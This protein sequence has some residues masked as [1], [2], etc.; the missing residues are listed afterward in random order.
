MRHVWRG[1]ADANDPARLQALRD[2]VAPARDPGS[3]AVKT[4]LRAHAEVAIERGVFGVPTIDVEGRLFWGLDSLP[5]VRS[6][7]HGDAWFDGPDW[8][9]AAVP[10]PGVVRG[11]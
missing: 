3:D 1:G 5:M 11:G 9:A 10:R 6:L 7:L 8:D 2:A 4:E